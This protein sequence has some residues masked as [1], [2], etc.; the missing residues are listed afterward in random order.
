MSQNDQNSEWKLAQEIIHLH[1]VLG[2]GFRRVAKELVSQGYR[3]SKDSANRFYNK[4][5]PVARVE[6]KGTKELMRFKLAET[7]ERQRLEVKT[8]KEEIRKRLN[9]LFV[10]SV[11]VTFE[12]RRLLFTDRERLLRFARKVMPKVDPLLWDQFQ[13]HCFEG[14]IKLVDAVSTALGRQADYETQTVE[15]E[16]KRQRL[17]LY[18]RD[19]L[20]A[21]LDRWTKCDDEIGD[22]CVN[23]E[24]QPASGE[25]YEVEI[26]SPFD[27]IR[28]EY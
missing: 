2:H 10:E 17:D 1:D 22:E 20:R 23:E 15:Y 5:K 19:R 28:G 3:L 13:D 12:R 14:E 16:N 9:I 4:Y 11:T 18:L 26:P 24:S 6:V 8:E 27:E 25:M 21:A 7:R